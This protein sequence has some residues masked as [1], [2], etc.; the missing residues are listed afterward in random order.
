MKYAAA[1]L[2]L[3][4]VWLAVQV[5]MFHHG[6]ANGLFWTGMAAALPAGLGPE[7][8]E[9]VDD[10]HGYD[11]QFYHLAAHDPFLLRGFQANVDNPRLRWR[12]IGV[13]GLAFL[14]ALGYDAWVDRAYIAVELAFVFFGAF[15]L[16]RFAERH[17]RSAAWGLAFF[18]VPAVL[19]SLERMTVDLPLAAL[20]IAF[21]LYASER[22]SWR[23]YAVLAAAPLVRETGMLLVIA[24]CVYA[25]LKRDN[26]AIRSGAMC[27]LPALAW[28]TYVHSRTVA[29]GTGWLSAFPF[30]GLIAQTFA[31]AAW[32]GGTPGLRVAAALDYAALAGIWLALGLAAYV[33]WKRRW[34]LVEL[35]AV[36]F[37]ASAAALGK[38]DIWQSAYAAGR[39]MSPLLV[40]LGVIAL[41]DRRLTF[42]APLALILPRI[43]FQYAALIKV[44]LERG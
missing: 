9:R 7:Q 2:V 3:A 40:V 38:A 20:T 23:I 33:V 5:L 14:L 28:W 37:A 30:G 39:I 29:D 17:R 16:A 26:A 15:W 42:A 35:T 34:G 24:W 21:A 22:R 32:P 13:P 43:A 36:V 6:R 11:G 10:P 18:A 44:M 19:V 8:T 27:A 41:R 25:F 31:G 12:R 4:A 1:A